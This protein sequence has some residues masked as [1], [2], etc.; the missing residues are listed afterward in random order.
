MGRTYRDKHFNE[1]FAPLRRLLLSRVDRPWDD[2]Y[3][4]IRAALRVRSAIHLHILQHL[5]HF[6]IL[7]PIMIDGEVH[8]LGYRGK[9]ERVV[10]SRRC[11]GYVDGDGMLRALPTRRRR[12]KRS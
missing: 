2:V 1:Y 3:S 7:H 8:V 4:E 10:R 5:E 12:K 6:V 9:I 11:C